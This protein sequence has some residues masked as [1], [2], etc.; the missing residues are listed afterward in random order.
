MS[1]NEQNR[2]T[3]LFS[4]LVGLGITLITGLI[5]NKSLI[6][7]TYF[8]WP[9]AWRIRLILAPQQNMWKINAF[10]FIVDF[11]IYSLI[12]FLVIYI[13]QNKTRIKNT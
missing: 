4:L 3:I 1:F 10:W 8:G 13:A 12:I 6:G 9:L 7:A 2:N 5:P 11:V